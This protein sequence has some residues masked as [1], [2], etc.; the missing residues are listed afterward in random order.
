M[1]AAVSNIFLLISYWLLISALILNIVG[2]YL[3]R[4]ASSGKSNQTL[5]LMNMSIIKIIISIIGIVLTTLQA[6]GREQARP[7]QI[8]DI[9]D[10]ALFC[11]NHQVVLIITVD[12][13]FAVVFPI[14]Y[15]TKDTRNILTISVA[16]AWL[17]GT[18]GIL[19]FFFI[20]YD[21]LYKIVYKIVFLT[22]DGLV[23]VTA[24]LTY[25]CILKQLIASRK[26]FSKASK[27]ESSFLKQ[28]GQFFC[29]SSLIMLSFILTVTIP[30]IVYV[31]LVI[32]KGYKDPYIESSIGLVW[33][34]Y[35][36]TDPL[37]YI[38]LQ[39]PI[40]RKLKQLITR[41]QVEPA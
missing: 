19:P 39:K 33:S 11:V 1:A 17:L 3:L 37:I 10:A 21:L 12:R 23:I 38:F 16:I 4:E 5:L 30:D 15:N 22:L 27:S 13:L 31:I 9:I 41:G 40:R 36:V 14:K 20:A 18:A 8:F 7:Y 25:S 6:C 29:I 24:L 35:L 26:K 2:V 34:I 28:H 32:N